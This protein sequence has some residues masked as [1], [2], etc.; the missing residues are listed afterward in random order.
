MTDRRFDPAPALLAA[1]IALLCALPAGARSLFEAR[2]RV[3]SET[4]KNVTNSLREV[5]DLLD[6]T[7]L[8]EL[9]P[10][11][12]PLQ[13]F[14]ATLDLRGLP[15]EVRWDAGP[16]IGSSTLT[17][18]VPGVIP[19][20]TFT[21]GTLE[22]DLAQLEDWLKG[23]LDDPNAPQDLLTRFLQAVVA[24]SPVEPVAGNPN[25]MMTRMTGHDFMLGSEGPFI[26]SDR[27]IPD[28][29]DQTGLGLHAGYASAGPYDQELLELPLDHRFNLRAAPNWS[30]LL[31][32]PIT[33][34]FTEGQWTAMGSLG[35]GFQ[36]RPFD[37]W[38]LTP[39]FRLGAVGS[40]DV[41][42][43]SLLYSGTLTS[44]I[45]F[46]LARFRG[47][48]RGITLGITNQAGF[49]ETVDGIT[50]GDFKLDY[51]LTNGVFRNGGYVRSTFGNSAWGWRFYGNDT[52]WAGSD[53]FLDSSA[54]IGLALLR[55]GSVGSKWAYESLSLSAAY[56]GDFDQW[57]GITV[58]LRGRF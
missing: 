47:G 31:S 1:L 6:G 54:E 24:N 46:D 50:I 27:R 29:P 4:E 18:S 9:F 40:L 35:L 28:A 7:A 38:A 41:G 33:A 30:V 44:D 5:P 22:E 2:I 19:E 17:F 43:A 56:V 25:S 20:I 12:T 53:L 15:A 49:S 23:I 48:L 21:T 32:F 11:W 8:L 39:M 37:W 55:I 52:R 13:D 3:G 42:A 36:Y 58:G 14:V 51:D 26:H 16:V 10:T 45:H 57:N 34:T